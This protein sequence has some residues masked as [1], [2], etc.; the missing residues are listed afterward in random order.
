LTGCLGGVAGAP[1]ERTVIVEA[2]FGSFT[3]SHLAEEV[4]VDTAD[5]LGRFASGRRNGDAAFTVHGHGDGLA[6]YLA[7]VPDA[8]CAEAV[9]AEVF[10]RAGV[11]P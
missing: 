9:L 10:A 4:H 3:G 1:G 7:T 6:Y 11:V 8:A 2:S 5:V